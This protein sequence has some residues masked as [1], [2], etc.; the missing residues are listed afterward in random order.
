MIPVG[1]PS[2]GTAEYVGV[3]A[4]KLVSLGGDRAIAWLPR[5]SWE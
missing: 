4:C 3:V 1:S 5:L 2:P